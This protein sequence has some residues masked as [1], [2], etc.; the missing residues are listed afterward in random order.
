MHPTGGV[1]Y[2]DLVEKHS[3]FK[4][5]SKAAKIRQVAPQSPNTT[6]N[7]AGITRVTTSVK[8]VFWQRISSQILASETRFRYKS[9]QEN[10]PGTG[11]NKYTCIVQSAQRALKMDPSLSPKVSYLE[12][13]GVP[14]SWRQQACQSGG[15]KPAKLKVLSTKSNKIHIN[16]YMRK[17]QE[18]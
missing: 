7:D 15:T 18:N 12:L 5:A 2:S 17:W 16:S 6:K 11:M 8:S 3:I 13:P 4:L 14:G 9:R 10:D 1:P